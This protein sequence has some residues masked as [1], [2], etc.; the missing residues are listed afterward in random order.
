MANVKANVKANV[1][2]YRMAYRMENLTEN[3]SEHLMEK[4][5]ASWSREVRV[6]AMTMTPK[7]DNEMAVPSLAAQI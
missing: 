5:S 3:P 4:M 7:K 1:M 6:M 2:A